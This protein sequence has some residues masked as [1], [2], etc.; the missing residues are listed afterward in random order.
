MKITIAQNK[1]LNALLLFMLFS[2]IAHVAVLFLMALTSFN[3][4][5]FNYFTILN[6][7]YI[8]PGFFTTFLGDVISFVVMAVLYVVILKINE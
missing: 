7:N 8:L 4:H 2:A 6:L 3:L 5:V 1:Y